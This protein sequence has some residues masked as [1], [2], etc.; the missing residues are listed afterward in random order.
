MELDKLKKQIGK[1]DIYLLDQILKG[2][3]SKEELILDAGCGFGR[4]L[5]W[6]YNNNFPVYAIDAN[7]ENVSVVKENYPNQKEHYTTNSVEN[8]PF[9]NQFFHH[10]V[11]IAVLHFAKNEAHLFEMISEMVRVLKANGTL[12]IRVASNIGL[13][14]KVI[15]VADGVYTLPDGTN[16]FLLNRVLLE[17]IIDTFNLKLLEPVKTVNVEDI[18]CMTTL[19]LQK[20]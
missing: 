16:R 13:E 2:R 1:T 20:K 12:F 14:K 19:M 3:Y 5:K 7:S 11:C 9:E 18:R 17:K 4:N 8:I 10:I 15:H 6:F